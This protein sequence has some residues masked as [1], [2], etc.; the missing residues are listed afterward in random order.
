MPLQS[1]ELLCNVLATGVLTHDNEAKIYAVHPG[2]GDN[3]DE[4]VGLP[5]GPSLHF[6]LNNEIFK[7][8]R[9]PPRGFTNAGFAQF[10]GSPVGYFYEDFQHW[11]DT[12]YAVPAGA[13]RAVVNLY[14]QST[15]KEFVEFLR[16]ENFTNSK[17][18]EMYDLWDQNGKCPPTLM[19]SSDIPVLEADGDADRD[20]LTNIEEEAY[21]SDPWNPA[22]ARRPV[23]STVDVDGVSHLCL[24]YD[25]RQDTGGPGL[26]LEVSL[27]LIEWNPATGLVEEI[28]VVDHLDGT[29]RVTVRMLEP[30]TAP[31]RQFMRVRVE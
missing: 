3:I 21:G 29:E 17:G 13:V 1:V 6:V 24:S 18:Q 12:P 11:D 23:S 5:V 8:N 27:D 14:Y 16:D 7:D 22:S 20:G 31:A 28:E 26:T 2:I 30:M 19:A 25:R 10:G 15:T 9:I 4:V